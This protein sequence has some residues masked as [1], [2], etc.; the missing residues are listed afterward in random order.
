MWTQWAQQCLEDFSAQ[1]ND[2]RKYSSFGHTCKRSYL[3]WTKQDIFFRGQIKAWARAYFN[4]SESIMVSWCSL[5]NTQRIRK[6]FFWTLMELDILEKVPFVLFEGFNS[7]SEVRVKLSHIAGE[8][9]IYDG[10]RKQ[11]SKIR[12]EEAD[13]LGFTCFPVSHRWTEKK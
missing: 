4:L 7:F 10:T 2:F 5:E 1:M 13:K 11:T 3:K 6:S 8:E 12:L 9:R